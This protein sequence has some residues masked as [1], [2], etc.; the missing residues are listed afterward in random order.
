MQGVGEAEL[1]W[2]TPPRGGLQTYV[3]TIADKV[4]ATIHKARNSPA[5]VVKIP[6]W[7]WTQP[8]AGSVAARMRL[9]ETGVKSFAD[10]STA[11]SAV[12][13]AFEHPPKTMVE[14]CLKSTNENQS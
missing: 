1:V 12:K 9:G 5:R 8:L 11:Q 7:V 14:I 10:L 3:A 2:V 13:H 4:V 6:G